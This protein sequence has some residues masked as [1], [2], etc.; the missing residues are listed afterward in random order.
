MGSETTAEGAAAVAAAAEEEVDD[1]DRAGEGGTDAADA[2]AGDAG[3]R[4]GVVMAFPAWTGVEARFC[5]S[6][7]LSF[8]FPSINICLIASSLVELPPAISFSMHVS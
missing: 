4:G 2:E 8:S 5:P 3:V 7:L 6:L 1:E